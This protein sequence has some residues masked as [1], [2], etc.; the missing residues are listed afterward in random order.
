L[1]ALA[2]AITLAAVRTRPLTTRDALAY[3][4]LML[5]AYAR[6]PDAFT[7]SADERATL[8]IAWWERRLGGTAP[9]SDAVFGAFHGER[10]VGVSGLSFEPRA[11]ARHKATLFGMY[12]PA[13]FRGCGIGRALVRAVLERARARR[14]VRLVQLTVT[15]GNAAARTLYERFGF[16]AFGLEPFAVAVG[17]GYVSKVHMWCDLADR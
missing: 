2:I 1:R 14:D 7:S 10:M 16:V 17:A 3:R 9:T 13:A 8:P 5:E 4:A 12:V 6:H 11:K 15:D